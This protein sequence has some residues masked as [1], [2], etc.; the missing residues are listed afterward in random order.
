VLSFA[1]IFLHVLYSLYSGLPPASYRSMR[2]VYNRHSRH[3]CVVTFIVYQW[4]L[5]CY[6]T[7]SV[8]NYCVSSSG[9]I[10][11]GLYSYTSHTSSYNGP[12]M[13]STWLQKWLQRRM[14]PDVK[15][16]F[17]VFP[18]NNRE[19]CKR[20]MKANPWKEFAPT[21]HSKLCS[22]HFKPTDLV[23]YTETA[24]VHYRL[25]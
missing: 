19:L 9:C 4:L 21:K 5:H 17:H 8:S 14:C 22:L 2:N 12:Q 1:L 3:R 24:I 6:S 16:S 20:W 10:F 15:I 18:L 13:C 11:R 25:S 7:V 23:E